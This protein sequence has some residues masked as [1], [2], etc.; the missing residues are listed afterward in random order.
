MCVWS[1]WVLI[2]VFDLSAVHSQ[3]PGDIQD[4]GAEESQSAEVRERAT[5]RDGARHLVLV[6][7]RSFG[8]C[9]Q[10]LVAPG[11]RSPGT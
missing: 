3:S 8:T 10:L 5:I 6:S 11:A 2:D 4:D 1:S 9:L 7:W